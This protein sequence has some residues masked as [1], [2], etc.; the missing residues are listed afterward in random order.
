VEATLAGRKAI[1][2]GANRGLGLEIARRFLAAGAD[3]AICA[4]DEELLTAEA[5]ALTKLG[6]GRVVHDKLDVTSE[7]DC[8]RFVER[9]IAEL[10]YL[11]V[12]V[13]NAGIYGPMGPIETV[14]WAKWV[15]AVQI[16]LMG[17]VIMSRC[18]LGHMKAR[19]R[20]SII[21][22]SGGGATNPLPGISAYAASKAAIVRFIE[23]LS[24]E[25]KAFGIDA[26]AIAPG[27]LN[28]RLLDEVLAAGPEKV[29]KEFYERSV[30]QGRDGGI[31][32]S[33]GADL[34]VFLASDA[35]RGITGKLI[36][37][38]WDK[39]EEWPKH[40]QELASS[41]VYTLRRI[42]GRERGQNWGDR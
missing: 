14:D 42:T 25:V 5:A 32:L 37:A 9:A 30:A 29:G 2:T 21:Q 22:I 3:I 38:L 17:S 41:D 35:A 6:Q 40:A 24:Q 15:D 7:A 18:V 4:R 39:W 10:G 12:L 27:A 8:R 1:I 16:N 36:S 11:D 19:G 20:G 31:P 34:V 33:K 23:T 13:N 28:T 26:N